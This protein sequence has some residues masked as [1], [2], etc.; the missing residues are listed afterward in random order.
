MLRNLLI[1]A[2]RSLKK[3]KFF[4]LLNM[5]GLG[6]GMAVFLLIALYVRFERSYEDFVTNRE[7]IYRVTLTTYVNNELVFAS[8]EN[9]P[10]VGPALKS[11]LPEVEAYARLY[12]MGYK[13][14]VI[15][16]REDAKPDP[17]AFKHRRFLYADSAFLPMMGY[18]LLKGDA[19]TALAD[20]LTAVISEH[21]ATMYFD[22]EDPLGKM[23]RLQD[24]DYNNELVKITGV[25]RDLPANT[26]LKFDILFSYETLYGRGERAPNRYN[27]SWGRKD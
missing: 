1:T 22:D 16:T 19:K 15:I 24:D 20:P 12:N 11:E 17:I 9:Y 26:H 27:L 10:G 5:V 25:F 14:N 8:A 21:Y 13:N 6:I 2:Y 23:L 7:N 3:N 4:S 18:E